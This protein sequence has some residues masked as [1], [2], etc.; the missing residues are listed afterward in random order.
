ML[1]YSG[2]SGRLRYGLGARSKSL[3][4]Q[5][6]TPG[7]AYSD[8]SAC[9]FKA[10]LDPAALPR[11]QVLQYSSSSYESD[12]RQYLTMSVEE[13]ER[14]CEEALMEAQHHSLGAG[15]A[16][17]ESELGQMKFEL[18]QLEFA[19]EY[20]TLVRAWFAYAT[21]H[22]T[23]RFALPPQDES[24]DC[25]MPCDQHPIMRDYFQLSCDM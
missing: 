7:L 11:L 16:A 25:R 4:L 23:R 10:L 9:G 6:S 3:K 14:E 15:N 12:V 5:L 19:L 22:V 8:V 1:T 2:S 18:G 20:G 13:L 24:M 21:V 17:V